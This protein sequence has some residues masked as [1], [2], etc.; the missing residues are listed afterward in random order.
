MCNPI[1]KL[2]P[3]AKAAEKAKFS[4]GDSLSIFSDKAYRKDSG[5]I[6]EAIGNVVV[7]SDKDTLYGEAATFD[8]RT[9]IFKVEGNVRF[10]S[11]EITLYGS[12]LEYHAVTGFAEIKNARIINTDF[13]IMAES[14]QRV[15]KKKFLA[16]KAEF[17]TC[18]D[19]AESWSIYGSKVVINLG[20]NIEITNGLVKIKSVSVIYIPYFIFPI[21]TD[22]K[23]GL[24]FPNFPSRVG[25]GLSYQQPFFWA[26]NN[27]QDL[28]LSPTFWGKRGYGGDI[29]Y[30]HQF[31]P[32]R[33]I[34]LETRLLNDSIYLP[35]K[36]GQNES[37]TH[38]FRNYSQ[39]E[40]HWQWSP[41]IT[42]HMRFTGARDLD[43]IRDFP[44]YTDERTIGSEMGFNGFLEWRKEYFN[45]GVEGSYLK[46]QLFS[47]A[48][49]LDES[50]VQSM[51][52]VYFNT[53]P[54]NL[55]RTKTPGL[56]SLSIGFEGK[57]NRF[58]QVSKNEQTYLRNVD[59]LSSSPYINW[60]IFSWGPLEFNSE[61]QF[62]YQKYHFNNEDEPGFEKHATIMKTSLSFS[63]D[64]IFGL[65]YEKE[66][67]LDK[68]SEKERE[69]L[70][71]AHTQ[72]PA[73]D[74]DLIGELPEFEKSL[75]T[76]KVKF[77][78]N[79]YRHSQEFKFIHHFIA[80]QEASGNARFA[81]QIQ[82]NEGWFDY[83]D[84]IREDEFE[85]GA[86]STRKIIP[87]K[88]TLE[89]QW[90]NTLIKKSPRS[91]D[92][93]V[94]DRYLRDNFKYQKVGYFNLS[95]GYQIGEQEEEGKEF[96]D[97]LTRLA[98]QTAYIAPKW[99]ISASE[100]Y[101]HQASQ[102]IFQLGYQRRFDML[103]FL[104]SYN[105]NSFNES[106]LNIFNVGLNLLPVDTIGLSYLKEIDFK[107]SQDL[108]TQYAIDIMPYNN[109]WI[110]NLNYSES[111]V[112]NRFSF[113]L[114]LNY[115]SDSF[116][117]Y[118][119]DFFNRRL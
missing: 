4:L 62:D 44:N 10:I 52:Q 3:N 16:Q 18:K 58:Y 35:G 34:D 49:K 92:P 94:D 105:Y 7:I 110:L 25:E 5:N 20:K 14:I 43:I 41:D 72:A 100:Y 114:V 46:N 60:N 81:Q 66:V 111:L 112:G 39:Y 65:S 90:N 27:S 54:I 106:N 2:I 78:V 59:R 11:N 47:R 61:A 56:R 77:S 51:P 86:S 89:F 30:R 50:Y 97:Q 108:R 83:L 95:Q 19:C 87:P 85:L 115:G 93:L 103:S 23:T 118:R 117:N 88:N 82:T 48:D 74:P 69:K 107:A 40:G 64:K 96:K 32:H 42:Q 75:T 57:Y 13:N 9:M 12:H 15:S 84:A 71:K 91:F 37:G 53:V 102:N 26:I 17:T 33:W 1:Y 119:N 45:L 73:P 113:N 6:F 21:Q 101:F 68:L 67:P 28:T 36:T 55:F 98:V 99:T 63:M 24:L 104:T 8:R 109:C 38:Y 22:R 70:K 29:E 76:D 80:N 31:A 79:S 116:E